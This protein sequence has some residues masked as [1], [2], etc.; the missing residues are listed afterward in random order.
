MSTE[1]PV[2]TL[3]GAKD[4]EDAEMLLHDQDAMRARL[5]QL[6]GLVVPPITFDPAGTAEGGKWELRING[7]V[8]T[9]GGRD[10]LIEGML[11]QF[12]VMKG[13]AAH[14]MTFVTPLVVAQHLN[15]LNEAYPDLV[16]TVRA[17]LS[18]DHLTALLRA[19]LPVQLSLRDFRNALEDILIKMV[20]EAPR[21]SGGA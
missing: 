3:V 19:R 20:D 21:R 16:R 2:L 8:M 11:P 18:I 5:F 12:A 14:G 13:F 15:L 1:A 4:A 10:E 6:T 9:S 17:V 7:E